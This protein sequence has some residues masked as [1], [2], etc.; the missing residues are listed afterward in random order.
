MAGLPVTQVAPEVRAEMVARGRALV[1]NPNY[2][3][4]D[5]IGKI[6]TLLA[7]NWANGSLESVVASPA[8]GGVST[9][10]PGRTDNASPRCRSCAITEHPHLDVAE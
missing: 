5:Q 1:A 7:A 10:E 3:S 6:A 4:K 9:S 8:S 2:P